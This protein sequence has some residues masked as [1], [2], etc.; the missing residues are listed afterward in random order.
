MKP[1][2]FFLL[3]ASLTGCARTSATAE[4]FHTQANVDYV[5]WHGGKNPRLIMRGV[6]HSTPTRAGGSLIGT[7]GAAGAGVITA[8]LT[9]G[10]VR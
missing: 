4:R 7:A 10:L 3:V 2:L 1:L 6:N 5:E 8:W 9:K